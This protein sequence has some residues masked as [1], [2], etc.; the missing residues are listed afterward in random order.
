MYFIFAFTRQKRGEDGDGWLWRLSDDRDAGEEDPSQVISQHCNHFFSYETTLPH[1]T[2]NV[3][4]KKSIIFNCDLCQ[5]G[6]LCFDKLDCSGVWSTRRGTRRRR[7][8]RWPPTRRCK[9]L[10][11]RIEKT[12]TVDC[13]KRRFKVAIFGSMR[14]ACKM[15]KIYFGHT[16][17]SWHNTEIYFIREAII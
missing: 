8:R 1:S 13:V 5:N 2:I 7:W 3:C 12:L 6:C 11:Q 16:G 9:G 10:K 17:H 15:R 4:L 14:T